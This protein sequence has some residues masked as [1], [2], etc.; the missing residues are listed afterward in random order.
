MRF[1][2][3]LLIL[4]LA[5]FS[6]VYEKALALTPFYTN[7]DEVGYFNYQVE[8]K[9]LYENSSGMRGVN[10]S[11]GA[12]SMDIQGAPIFGITYWQG[13][14]PNYW[15]G[16]A[17][18][19]KAN[20][21]FNGN[22]IAG[23]ALTE[24]SGGDYGLGYWANV[25]SYLQEGN[26]NYTISNVSFGSNAATNNGVNNGFGITAVSEDETQSHYGRLIIST[27]NDYAWH[28]FTGN[29]GPNTGVLGFN[30]DP[31]NYD[32]QAEVT[33][34]YGGGED[35]VNV[36]PYPKYVDRRSY[37]WYYTANS[38]GT[39]V[40]LVDESFAHQLP[41]SHILYARDGFDWDTYSFSVNLPANTSVFALQTESDDQVW[42]GESFVWLGSNVFIP[43][44]VVPEP[45]TLILFTFGAGLLA[46]KRRRHL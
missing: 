25:T 45:A 10:Q 32:R 9:G 46:L 37:V 26:H 43:E 44:H 41:E 17:E 13:Y 35:G 20:V 33:L 27:A 39:P 21:Q 40:D 11:S 38:G 28:G 24:S 18:A 12:I 30:I 6:M 4:V 14:G 8:G 1:R 5:A 2:I 42:N 15:S 36:G 22:N 16:G 31:V 29:N 19:G 3:V 7:F 34:V 23:T